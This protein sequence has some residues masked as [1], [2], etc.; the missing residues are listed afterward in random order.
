MFDASSVLPPLIFLLLSNFQI[1]TDIGIIQLHAVASAKGTVWIL[2][3]MNKDGKVCLV[4][5]LTMRLFLAGLSYLRCF[6]HCDKSG[7]CIGFDFVRSVLL[8]KG[9]ITEIF[10]HI[11]FT[12]NLLYWHQK[13]VAANYMQPITWCFLCSLCTDVQPTFL[14]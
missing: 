8:K 1:K 9:K 14:I 12:L 10:C 5:L 3:D 6:M 11:V 2:C 7:I 13:L 4:S